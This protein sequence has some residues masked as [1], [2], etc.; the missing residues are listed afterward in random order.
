MPTWVSLGDRWHTWNKPWHPNYLPN[1]D[2]ISHLWSYSVVIH[3]F[4]QFILGIFNLSWKYT[5]DETPCTHTF[6]QIMYNIANPTPGMFFGGTRR[7]PTLTW[8]EHDKLCTNSNQSEGSNW[9]PSEVILGTVAP[10]KEYYLLTQFHS[11]MR[12]CSVC[13]NIFSREK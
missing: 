4:I 1:P 8:G 10:C 3:S 9:G 12:F 11:C 5:L 13:T 6:T 7:T 2:H